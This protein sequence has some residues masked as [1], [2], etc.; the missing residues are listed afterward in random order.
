MITTK[1]HFYILPIIMIMLLLHPQASMAWDD[2][3]NCS[4]EDRIIEKAIDAVFNEKPGKK[5]KF[6]AWDGHSVI[7][8]Q[9]RLT[10]RFA[11]ENDELMLLK[12]NR[13]VV[14]NKISYNSYGNAYHEIFQSELPLFVTADSIF[15]AMYLGN[16]AML[17]DLESKILLPKLISLLSELRNELMENSNAIGKDAQSDVDL[18]LGVALRLILGEGV[19]TGELIMPHNASA[20]HDVTAKIMAGGKIEKVNLFGRERMVDFSQYTV[21]GHYAREELQLQGYFRAAMWLSRLEFNLVSRSCRSSHPG[22]ELD[23]S[24]TDRETIAAMALASLLNDKSSADLK[25]LLDSWTFFAGMREDAGLFEIRDLLRKSGAAIDSGGAKKLRAAIGSGMARKVNMHVMPEGTRELPVIATMI[26]ARITPD[27]GLTRPLTDPRTPGRYTINL[28]DHLYLMGLD[29]SK[30]YL[31]DD[32]VQFKDLEKNLDAARR[33]SDSLVFGEDLYSMWFKAI[34]A[35][36]EKPSGTFP[37]FMKMPVYEDL[38]INTLA[39]AFAQLKHNYVLMGAQEYFFGGCKIPDAY[40]EPALASY[41]A[42]LAY[43]KAGEK[44][45]SAVDPDSSS[46]SVA[47]YRRVSRILGVLVKIVENELNGIP[48]SKN[49]L[50]FLGR[51]TN[52]A[53]GTTGSAPVYDGWYFLL[54][55]TKMDGITDAKLMADFYTSPPADKIQYAGIKKVNIGYF[56]VD[57]GGKQRLMAGPVADAFYLSGPIAKRYNDEDIFKVAVQQPWKK[58][59]QLPAVKAPS[60]AVEITGNSTDDKIRSYKVTVQCARRTTIYAEFLDHNRRPVYKV[61]LI[62]DVKSRTLE[63]KFKGAGIEMVHVSAESFHD[64]AEFDIGGSLYFKWN[65]FEMHHDD[66]K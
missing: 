48:L 30:A 6:S 42:L 41:R 38:R 2:Q 12:K 21:R 31:K 61:P 33:N 50:D 26:G 62:A 56:V 5:V 40:V 8:Y 13:F 35:I 25:R 63:I 4:C 1:L 11:L 16:D 51:V 65:N 17:I 57:T 37:S 20:L 3:A 36:S 10:E 27:L 39:A 55:Y 7:K 15:N 60:L 29:H 22:Q 23:I 46:G 58:N 34:K 54:H 44:I 45:T 59:Y 14:S 28:M 49:E 64:W 43:A 32:L 19:K 9:P 18:Y 47:Y 66:E 53:G 24:E 52:L